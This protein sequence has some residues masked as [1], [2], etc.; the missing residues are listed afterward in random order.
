MK[1]AF[2]PL[3]EREYM[4]A[5]HFYLSRQVR[6]ATR[7]DRAVSKIVDSLQTRTDIGWPHLGETRQER[8]PG[9]PYGV[10]FV[11]RDDFTLV[12]AV[13]HSSR[14]PGYWTDRIP[15]NFVSGTPFE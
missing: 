10:I 7:F 12:V 9:F 13:A 2:H 11:S 3:A 5:F 6:V 8:V 1:V 4:E 15:S 14:K